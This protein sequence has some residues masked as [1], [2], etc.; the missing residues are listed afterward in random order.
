L[1]VSIISI[2][3]TPPGGSPQAITSDCVYGAWHFTSQM[4]ATPGQFEGVVRDYT[5]THEFTTGGEIVLTCDGVAL[6]GGYILVATRQFALPVADTTGGAPEVELRQWALSGSDYNW[7]LDKLVFRNT[8]DYLSQVSVAGPIYDGAIIRSHLPSYLDM[9]SGFDF[10]THVVDT[11]Q[12]AGAYTFSDGSNGQGFPVRAVLNDLA[13]Y[14]SVAYMGPD[15]K[16]RFIPVQDAVAPFGFSDMPDGSS[17]IGFSSGSASEDITPMGNDAFVWGGSAWAGS[18]GVVASRRTNA[19]S[20]TDHGRWQYAEVRVGDLKIQAQTDA[21][22]NVIVSGNVTGSTVDGQQGIALPEQTYKLTWNST[23]TPVVGGVPQT[24][25]PGQVVPLE[26]WTF[27]QDGGATPWSVSVPC[28]SI[29]ISY[30]GLDPDGN[31]YVEFSGTFGLLVS[32]PEW[33][34]SYLRRDLAGFRRRVNPGGSYTTTGNGAT[35]AVPYG[36]LW[37][38]SPTPAPNG[39]ATV[40]TIE[41]SGAVVHGYIAGSTQLWLNGTTQRL[42][43]DYTE[44]DPV[45]GQV[46][47]T[48]PDRAPLVTGD[49]LWLVCRVLS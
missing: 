45:N 49:V 21:R 44:S 35:G 3:Y 2:V 8:A 43:T 28:R 7:Q 12:F 6:W 1:A 10:S 40:F 23:R 24:L 36:S 33:L 32:D 11:F 14:G 13:Q 46:T 27:S 19:T 5:Q 25:Y 30:P 20:V 48:S 16:L 42:G 17:F 18:G 39:S 31:P 4:A 34:W 41:D 26:L 29:D 22:A 47:W 15:K 9:P 37:N 38:G